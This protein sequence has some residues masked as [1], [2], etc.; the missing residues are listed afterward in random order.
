MGVKKQ[1][2]VSVALQPVV[3]SGL[4]Q[5]V[6]MTTAHDGTNRLFIVEQAGPI[7]VLQPGATS[8][9]MFLDLTPKVWEG[10]ERGVLGLAFHPNYSTNRRFFVTYTL[11][12]D[13][14]VILAEY[15]ASISNPNQAELT[16]KVILAI[17]HPVPIHNGG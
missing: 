11:W 1:A 9:T 10:G 13:G 16:E 12:P 17:P 3:T 4:R 2:A 14:S 7:K 8:P 6:F 15:L 5:P